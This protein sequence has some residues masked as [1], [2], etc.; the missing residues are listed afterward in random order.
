MRERSIR[1][2]GMIAPQFWGLIEADFEPLF[3]FLGTQ[4]STSKSDLNLE[5]SRCRAPF[6]ERS[7]A[8]I[9]IKATAS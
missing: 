1:T 2:Y 3:G 9:L 5:I 6:F 7:R 8:E 4:N